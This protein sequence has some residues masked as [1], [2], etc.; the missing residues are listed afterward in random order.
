MI[1][2]II[3]DDDTIVGIKDKHSWTLEDTVSVFENTLNKFFNSDVEVSVKPKQKATI[4][5]PMQEAEGM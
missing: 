4:E 5:V 2:I 1:K 3:E